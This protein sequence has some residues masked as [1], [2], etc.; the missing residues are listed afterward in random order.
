MFASIEK[1]LSRIRT[2]NPKGKEQNYSY[3]K[4]TRIGKLEVAAR[5]LVGTEVMV[6]YTIKISNLGE[7]KAYISEIIDELPEDLEFD[8]SSNSG[9]YEEGG[10]LRYTNLSEIEVGQT[11]E[12]K[13]IATIK[14]TNDNLGIINN[15]ATINATDGNNIQESNT[16]NNTSNAQ[17]IIG[18]STGRIV[19]NILGMVALLAIIG[20]GLFII[21]KYR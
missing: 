12:I 21:K 16:Q 4:G 1:S 3:D 11:R 9:W 14:L 5:N 15:V 10:K 7:S 13:L 6:E 20:V 19:L 2:V 17:L 18:T 8:A